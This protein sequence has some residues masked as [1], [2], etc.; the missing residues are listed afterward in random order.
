MLSSRLS[1]YTLTF[2]QH[3]LKATN[4]YVL[5]LTTEEELAGLPQDIVAAAAAKAKEKGLTGW[6]FDLSAPS[7]SAFMKYADRRDLR[8]QLYE[9]YNSRCMGGEW[10]NL[11]LIRNIVNARLALAGLMDYPSYADYVLRNR[12]AGTVEQVYGLLDELQAGFA[13]TAQEEQARL[14]AYAADAPELMPYDWSY[15]A[16]KLRREQFEVSDEVLRPYFALEQVKKGIFGLATRLYGITF[17]RNEAIEV[18]HP[19]VEAYEVFDADGRYLAVFY[20]DFYPRSG[21]RPGAWMTDFQ[22]QE[23]RAGED[24]RP[25]ISI[26]M[27]FTRPTDTQPALLTFNEVSTFLHEFGH[28]LHGILADTTYPSLSGTGVYQDFVELPSQLM[29]NFLLEK[30]F[31][32]RFAVHYQ[33]GETIPQALV[34]KLIRASRFHAGYA[35]LRQLT[36]GR[37]DMAYH[38]LR[39]PIGEDVA[40]FE[41]EA[42]RPTTLLPAV[43]GTLI[44][45]AFSHIFAG[46]Y[47]AGYYSYKWAEV[48]DADAFALFKERG[49]AETAPA[50]RELLSKGGTEDP[51]ALYLHFRGRQPTTEALMRRSGIAR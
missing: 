6:C 13:P 22:G 14:R 44:S 27:N 7:F 48:L 20:A 16:E 49:I 17:V 23:K 42:V 47:A 3:V 18:Y 32:D 30:D 41:A 38:T 19:D 51:M 1:A 10:D 12:M 15:Y 37:L 8:K 39:E 4:D 11:P 9:A 29:E 24:I 21:K 33:T 25:H 5:T 34:E 31:L 46:G 36:F 2:G 28:A 50:F 43:E 35:C 26:V 45:P 40:A